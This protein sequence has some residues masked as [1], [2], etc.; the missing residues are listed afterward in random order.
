[1]QEEVV[2][3]EVQLKR[4]AQLVRVYSGE[5]NRKSL[6][7]LPN[8]LVIHLNS[9]VYSEVRVLQELGV[10]SLQVCLVGHQLRLRQLLLLIYLEELRQDSLRVQQVE[11]YLEGPLKRLL[12][13]DSQASLDSQILRLHRVPK[14]DHSDSL[15]LNLDNPHLVEVFFEEHQPNHPSFLVKLPLSLAVLQLQL[16]QLLVP[17]SLEELNSSNNNLVRQQLDNPKQ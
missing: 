13:E 14:Q 5:V 11:A 1:M 7:G 2:Y 9:Q 3:L 17:H 6:Q 15:K 4:R 16:N 12:L 10:G 8:G